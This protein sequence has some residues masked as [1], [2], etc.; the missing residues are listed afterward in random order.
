MNTKRVVLYVLFGGFLSLGVILSTL[1]YLYNDP[2]AGLGSLIPFIVIPF[3][4]LVF[5]GLTQETAE[6]Y[7]LSWKRAIFYVVSTA[8]IIFGSIVFS[9]M[10]FVSGTGLPEALATLIPFAL[11]GILLLVFLVLTEK[12][13]RKPWVLKQQEEWAKLHNTDPKASAKR[14]LLSGALWIFAIA[15]VITFGLIFGFK[16]SWVIILFAIGIE[17]LI[18]FFMLPKK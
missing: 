7:P 2:A 13:H 16:Y 12:D 8:L 10:F 5:M 3:S 4:G 6:K 18:T 1:T 9:M 17:V 15:L 11:P 14:G